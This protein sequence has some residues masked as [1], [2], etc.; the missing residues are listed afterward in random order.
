MRASAAAAIS[1][2]AADA[3]AAPDPN[4]TD[5]DLARAL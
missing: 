1:S 4:A 5:P 3:N 2:V